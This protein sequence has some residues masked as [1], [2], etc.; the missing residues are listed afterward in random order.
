MYFRK[1]NEGKELSIIHNKLTVVAGPALGSLPFPACS[2]NSILHDLD[3]VN[4]YKYGL[5]NLLLL[6]L[7]VWELSARTTRVGSFSALHD[8]INRTAEQ[9][10]KKTKK[11]S[12]FRFLF[13]CFLPVGRKTDWEGKFL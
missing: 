10:N 13:C 6:I 1:L 11:P 3:F 5:I 8:R 12:I 9:Y 4:V 7:I 2:L